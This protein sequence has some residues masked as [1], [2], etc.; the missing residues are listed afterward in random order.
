MTQVSPNRIAYDQ[1]FFRIRE[2]IQNDIDNKYLTNEER[3]EEYKNMLL[4]IQDSLF[5]PSTKYDPYINGE[6]PRSD[7]LNRFASTLAND[8]NV[9]AK[10]VDYLNAKTVNS[11]NLFNKELETEKE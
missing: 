9:L 8:L 5:S 7:K 3:V 10:Q 11:F 1:I 4:D 2:F 6:P